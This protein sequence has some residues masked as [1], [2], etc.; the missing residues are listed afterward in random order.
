MTKNEL[1]LLYMGDEIMIELLLSA[2]VQSISNLP[3]HIEDLIDSAGDLIDSIGDS[4]GS[5]FQTSDPLDSISD[6]ISGLENSDTSTLGERALSFCGSSESLEKLQD[7]LHD[8]T[9]DLENAGDKLEM[10]E[11]WI[12]N[13]SPDSLNRLTTDYKFAER[14]YDKI[15]KEVAELGAKIAS[16]K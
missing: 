2:L 6:I 9:L 15:A 8:K 4:V 16:K 5:I 14:D 13:A 11:G 12:E 7:A 1:I 3:D 10:I